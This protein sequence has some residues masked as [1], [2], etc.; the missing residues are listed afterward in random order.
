MLIIGVISQL[1]ACS[2]ISTIPPDLIENQDDEF[3]VEISEVNDLF[4]GNI[5]GI[6]FVKM[7]R[8]HTVKV[9]AII[10]GKL[11]LNVYDARQT[12]VTEHNVTS[13][14]RRKTCALV[15][16]APACSND[17]EWETLID[18]RNHCQ[19]MSK[20]ELDVVINIKLF[21]HRHNDVNINKK[22]HKEKERESK[23]HMGINMDS[24]FQGVYQIIKSTELSFYYQTNVYYDYITAAEKVYKRKVSLSEFKK[25]WLQQCPHITYYFGNQHVL[26][27]F[28][29]ITVLIMPN[30]YI[31]HAMH[32]MWGH[33]FLKHQG[34]G[35]VLVC[36]QR[37]LVSSQIFYLIDKAEQTGK[38]ANLVASMLHHHFLYRGYGKTDAALHMDN[39]SV[40]SV[41]FRYGLWRVMTGQHDSIRFSLMEAGHTKFHPDW[42]FGLWKVKWRTATV[43]TLKELGDSVTK[44]SRNEHDIQQLVTDSECP[45]TLYDWRGFLKKFFKHSSSEKYANDEEE[46][47]AITLLKT[48]IFRFENPGVLPNI[49]VP[50]GL[51]ASKQWYLFEEVGPY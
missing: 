4:L 2:S 3:F 11:E 23:R 20:E 18:Y 48:K 7:I 44:S 40:T 24:L 1:S 13:Q 50:K 5:L 12:D 38:G 6:P 36:G 31:I 25:L 19:E 22:K 9:T 35:S 45:V 41:F 17:I 16:M 28:S 30:K 46:E 51:H 42:H 8:T 39:C 43:E 37:V 10:E 27:K 21:H 14:F 34:N 29:Y 47:E 32:S 33:W 15:N 26:H 49:L